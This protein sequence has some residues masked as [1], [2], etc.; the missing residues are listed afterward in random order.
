MESFKKNKAIS[1]EKNKNDQIIN[2]KKK[3]IHLNSADSVSG[4]R[5]SGV[6]HKQ[7]GDW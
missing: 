4:G 1:T 5:L 7:R 2:K 3:R 6:E